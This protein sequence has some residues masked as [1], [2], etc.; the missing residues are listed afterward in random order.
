MEQD[1]RL[2]KL[3]EQMTSDR[4]RVT[5]V[6]QRYRTIVFLFLHFTE[7]RRREKERRSM[8]KRQQ[9]AQQQR[10]RRPVEL[11]GED[12]DHDVQILVFADVVVSTGAKS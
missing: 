10:Q 4:R 8:V 11:E 3:N 1:V 9:M 7:D 5:K 12:P 6:E 2:M